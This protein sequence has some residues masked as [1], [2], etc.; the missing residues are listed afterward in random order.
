MFSR[1]ILEPHMKKF[2]LNFQPREIKYFHHKSKT[3]LI[4]L[5]ISQWLKIV[6]IFCDFYRI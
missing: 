5:N 6:K 4:I 3:N 1:N 2:I